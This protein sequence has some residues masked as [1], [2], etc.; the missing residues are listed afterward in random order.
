MYRLST[1]TNKQ[2]ELQAPSTTSDRECANISSVC[3]EGTH[4]EESPPTKTSD[5]ICKP[6]TKD[7]SCP[8][9]E[10]LIAGNATTDNKC[11]AC[12]DGQYATQGATTCIDHNSLTIADCT[13][14]LL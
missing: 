12:P 9:G 14:N 10:K 6:Y 11:T 3:T 1:C 8:A 4:W 2:Y 13:G 5:R 7:L